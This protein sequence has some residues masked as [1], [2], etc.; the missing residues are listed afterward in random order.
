[1]TVEEPKTTE[2]EVV[3]TTPTA[4]EVMTFLVPASPIRTSEPK[5]TLSEEKESNAM[6]E[7]GATSI[8]EMA[9]SAIPRSRT[10]SPEPNIITSIEETAIEEPKTTTEEV[11]TTPTE[12]EVSASGMEQTMDLRLNILYLQKFYLII[13][14]SILFLETE[15]S[16]SEIPESSVIMSETNF[17]RS[18]TPT[19][20]RS[21]K[22]PSPSTSQLGE[23]L[24]GFYF[25][26]YFRNIGNRKRVIGQWTYNY[27]L[28]RFLYDS[29]FVPSSIND[30]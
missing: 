25:L 19:R 4:Q 30:L 9:P 12:L 18:V 5:T 28:K 22:S 23:L 3:D 16:Q 13:D 20:S 11:N 1:M 27:D 2:A 21:R 6:Q 10:P 24:V 8:H 26:F 17:R 29:Y 15:T 7:S 14:L